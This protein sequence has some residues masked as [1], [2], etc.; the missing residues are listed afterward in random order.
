VSSNWGPQKAEL[1]PLG[2][3]RDGEDAEP[4]SLMQH[5]VEPDD[6][7]DG[8]LDV[9]RGRRSASANPALPSV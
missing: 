1:H 5:V 6:R 3:V 4:D 9:H 2:L 7:M 8:F